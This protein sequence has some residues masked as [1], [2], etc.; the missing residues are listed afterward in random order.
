MFC[1][2]PP[3]AERGLNDRNKSGFSHRDDHVK[4]M[5]KARRYEL[6]FTPVRGQKHAKQVR[7][8]WYN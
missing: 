7:L 4:P 2:V 3:Q 6:H 8:N 5:G 1:P